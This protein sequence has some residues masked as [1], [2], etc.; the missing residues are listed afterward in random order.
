MTAEPKLRAL[1]V[2][3]EDVAAGLTAALAACGYAPLA[4]A[5]RHTLVHRLA[6]DA[7]DLVVC[8]L[9]EVD[10]ATFDALAGAGAGCTR[11]VFTDDGA[12]AA[13]ERA[14]DAGVHAWEVGDYA[15]E[16]LAAVLRLARARARRDAAARAE[17]AQA[18]VALDERKW[19]DR[20]K[21]VLMNARRI[22]EEEAFVLLRNASMHAQLRVG[23]VSR[24]VI[25]AA[26]AADAV[27]RAG[28][29]RMLS[30][31][32]V[33]LAAQRVGRI[34]ARA[35]AAALDSSCERVQATL[36][37]LQAAP[38]AAARELDAVCNAWSALAPLLRERASARQLAAADAAAQRLLGAAED[39]TAA[40]EAHGG[41]WAVQIVNLCGRQRMRAQRIAKDM[42]L[43]V[44]LQGEAA[45]A[46]RAR[47]EQ[48]AHEFEH[49]LAELERAPLTSATI[50]DGLAAARDE[51]QRMQHGI[52]AVAT[53]EGRSA[54]AASSERLLEHFEALTAAYET[55]LQVILGG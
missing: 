29:L 8:R 23:E 21:G 13:L 49:T 52:R 28:Q 6:V 53:P 34:D 39:L 4:P 24:A 43:A 50:R 33:R 40:L 36:A 1:L 3:D 54:L 9:R 19:I 14:L 15:P 55:S 30:Q 47:A 7:P 38:D 32:L 48:T 2:A 27:N 42:L 5:T 20:A 22:G 17:L 25:E 35:A 18:R 45:T 46:A 11:V 31:R 44:L 10:A 12:D 37:G 26:Q 16:R 41:R 51:W